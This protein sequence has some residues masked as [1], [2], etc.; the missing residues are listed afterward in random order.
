MSKQILIADHDSHIRGII[1]KQISRIGLKSLEART[2]RDALKIFGERSIDLILLETHIPDYDGLDVCREVRK[3][4]DVPIVFISDHADDIDRIIG[5]ELGA[6]DYIKKPFNPR[7]LIARIKAILK[8]LHWQKNE[9]QKEQRPILLNA[10][11][12]SVNIATHQVF[13]QK[14]E[15]S[16]TA[17]EFS[18][19]KG[20]IRHPEMVYTRSQIISMAYN[21]HIYVSSRTIDSHIRHIRKKFAC[22][23]CPGIFV[24]IHGVGYKLFK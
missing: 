1:S 21:G 23:G 20:M 2:G 16:L 5:Y 4:S 9:R 18:I 19:I 12:L 24:T 17:T 3:I 15:I 6:D 14:N 10:K 8:R 7:E 22:F 11:E 13:W